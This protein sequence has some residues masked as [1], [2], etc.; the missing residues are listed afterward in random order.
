MHGEIISSIIQAAFA[1]QATLLQLTP[2]QHPN[3]V[4]FETPE[5]TYWRLTHGDIAFLAQREDSIVGTVSY[6]RLTEKDGVGYIKRLAILP[7]FRGIGLGE[8]LM[9]QAEESLLEAGSIRAEIS[10]VADF[11]HLHRY[12]H[13]L[14]YQD[15]LLTRVSSLPF[16]VQYLFKLL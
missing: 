9:H 8:L 4:G 14:G 15:G 11:S 5:R 7:V 10:I 1:D 13:R 16:A 3:F 12:Y 2:E 6:Q